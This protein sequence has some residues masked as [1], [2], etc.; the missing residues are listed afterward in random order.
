MKY[1]KL[2]SIPGG[3]A[4]GGQACT[5]KVRVRWGPGRTG[6]LAKCSRDFAEGNQAGQIGDLR[7]PA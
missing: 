6:L 7:R 5:G 4:V 3:F 2:L 1:L